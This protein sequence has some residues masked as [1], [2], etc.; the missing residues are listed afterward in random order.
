MLLFYPLS[1]S[2][3]E[4]EAIASSGL[5][6][7]AGEPLGL[8]TT[9]ASAQGAGD[10]VLVVDSDAFNQ[11]PEGATPDR[12]RVHRLP[13][14]AVQNAAPYRP[15]VAVTA[16][17]GLVVRPVGGPA[18][19]D[20]QPQDVALLVI[21]RRGCWDLPKG[22]QDPGESV[23][24]CARREVR[25]EVGIKRLAVRRPVGVTVHG[26]VDGDAYAVKTTHWYVMQTPERS[27]TPERSEGIRRVAWARWATA[28][29]HLGYATL[30]THLQRVEADVRKAVAE[31]T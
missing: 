29:R 10:R 30:R 31:A 15:P 3:P 1:S 26:Y 11:R 5:E 14:E 19:G 12:V 28:C 18:G 21:H 20:G 16:A 22:K 7:P 25:E 24:A 2:D 8:H 4:P 6:A 13:P 23:E 27:F 17:G 9:L